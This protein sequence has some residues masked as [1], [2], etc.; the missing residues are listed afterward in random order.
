M[1]EKPVYGM[2]RLCIAIREWRDKSP[3]D[4]KYRGPIET[5]SDGYQ[6]FVPVKEL[7]KDLADNLEIC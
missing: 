5:F 3:E 1:E 4:F 2:R 7:A 6:A